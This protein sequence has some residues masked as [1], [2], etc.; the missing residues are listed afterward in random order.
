MAQ[1]ELPLSEVPPGT[2]K[3]VEHDGRKL[4]VCNA[5]GTIHAIQDACPH[6]RASLS[7]GQLDGE[8]IVCPWHASK[9][10]LKTGHP[11]VWVA[12]PR[13]LH[14]LAKTV[15]GFFRR[16]KI[17]PARVEGDRIIIGE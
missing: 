12:K 17:Y 14:W 9:F 2:I 15:P 5:N 6:L 16:A 10:D 8:T 3:R 13:W 1:T 7:N 11:V 4:A